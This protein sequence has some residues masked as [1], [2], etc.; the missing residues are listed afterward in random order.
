M[1]QSRETRASTGIAV[2]YF[3]DNIYQSPL[4]NSQ[5]YWVCLSYLFSYLF[6]FILFI[7]FIYSMKFH[8]V[9]LGS[10]M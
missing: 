8:I 1:K 2:C 4:R 6:Y 9:L 3:T 5:I 7:E 10:N